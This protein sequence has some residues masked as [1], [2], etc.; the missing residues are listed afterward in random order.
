MST[1]EI[2]KELHQIIDNGDENFVQSFYEMVKEFL[3]KTD[4]TKMIEESEEDIKLG[5][6]HSQAEVSKMIE[7]WRK[8]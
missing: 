8:M 6:I 5:K 4:T 7:G 1:I 3:S 2:K